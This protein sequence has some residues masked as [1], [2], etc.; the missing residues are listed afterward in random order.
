MKVGIIGFGRLGKLCASHMIKDFDLY[1][2]DKVDFKKEIKAM[3]AKPVQMKEFGICDIIIPFVPISEFENTMTALKDIL[4]P[5]CL[6]IDVCSVKEHPINVM[7]SL[8]SE[9]V[10]IL[11]T[12]PMFGPDSAR[13]TLF[14]TKIALCPERIDQ[15]LYHNIKS[16]LH[17][18]GVKT[19][20]TT[21]EKH[22]KE[23]ASTLVLTH[24]IGRT[25]VDMKVE[26]HEIDTKGYRRLLKI[27][28]TVE[29]DSWQLFDD[30]N[31][32]NQFSKPTR[33]AFRKSLE[34]ILKRLEH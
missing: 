28:Q 11:G 27:L 18:N 16:Y 20:E 4:K 19:I 2:Y 24:V 33:E 21:P 15:D 25:L 3:K 29:N 23:I 10:Q 7:K 17:R 1:I 31:S 32:Y 13:D 14:G 9:D 12:H 34:N 6:I 30:M 8:L 22:D 5:G 26:D